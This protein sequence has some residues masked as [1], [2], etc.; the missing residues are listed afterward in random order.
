MPWEIMG[1]KKNL[2]NKSLDIAFGVREKQ[3][4]DENELHLSKMYH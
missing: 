2:Q 4:L 1:V 3:D